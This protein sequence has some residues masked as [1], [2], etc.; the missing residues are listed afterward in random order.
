MTGEEMERA[1]EFLLRSQANSEARIARLEGAQE[2]TNR[3]IQQNNQQIQQIN[4]QIGDLVSAQE[5]TRQHLE[6]LGNIVAELVEGHRSNKS[7]IDA[8]V[9]LVGGLYEQRNG[10]TGGGG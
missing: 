3:Q 2:E 6:H 1:V 10:G 5:R 4:Q 8:L 7:D 9:K